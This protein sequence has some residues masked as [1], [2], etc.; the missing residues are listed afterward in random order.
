M[1]VGRASGAEVGPTRGEMSG[2]AGQTEIVALF[3]VRMRALGVP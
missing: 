1:I 3:R 2:K